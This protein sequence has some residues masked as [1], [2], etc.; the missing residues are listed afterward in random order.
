MLGFWGVAMLLLGGCGYTHAACQHTWELQGGTKVLF[1]AHHSAVMH[2][3]E[4]CGCLV[5]A[6]MSAPRREIAQQRHG[7]TG[8]GGMHTLEMLG[9]GSIHGS[10]GHATSVILVTH[11]PAPMQA[12]ERCG[13]LGGCAVSDRQT[14]EWWSGAC[15]MLLCWAGRGG[16]GRG[17]GVLEVD[18]VILVL[19]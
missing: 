3:D 1:V 8:G 5:G 15:I 18:V 10:C 19:T 9:Q 17:G 4:H 12:D 2:A 6:L 14:G 13:W 16:A 11:L 7:S